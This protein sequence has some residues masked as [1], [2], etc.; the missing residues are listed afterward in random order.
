M[1]DG[2]V[3]LGETAIREYNG[4]IQNV[5]LEP[6]VCQPASETIA[7]IDAAEA[8]IIG[9]G[10]LY[11]SIIPNL[12]VAGIPQAISKA[13]GRKI[14]VSNIMTEAGETDELDVFDH[15]KTINKYLGAGAIDDILYSNTTIDKNRLENYKRERARPVKLLNKE[16]IAKMK[17]RIIEEDLVANYDLAW[18][19]SD[20]LAETIIKIINEQ[21]KN[22]KQ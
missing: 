10:S 6:N 3:I 15:L 17:V 16:E 11:T 4:K 9:P 5:F 8:I 14:Y 22:G 21:R 1:E 12:L 19:D 2:A 18:H 7:A 13:P 20:K